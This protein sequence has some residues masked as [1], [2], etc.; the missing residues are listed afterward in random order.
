M[1]ALQ[2]FL[3]DCKLTGRTR[4]LSL[5]GLDLIVKLFE[6]LAH[7]LCKLE[8]GNACDKHLNFEESYRARLGISRGENHFNLVLR[9]VDS[10]DI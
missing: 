5:F 4:T 7:L 3:L 8:I 6:M 10:L 2:K 9:S 1:V